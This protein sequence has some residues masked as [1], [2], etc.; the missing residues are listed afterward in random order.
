MFWNSAILDQLTNSISCICNIFVFTLKKIMLNKHYNIDQNLCCNYIG[1]SNASL[2]DGKMYK[3]DLQWNQLWHDSYNMQL[4]LSGVLF[5]G[6]YCSELCTYTE[7]IY[8]C[9]QCTAMI[10]VICLNQNQHL[11]EK[12][13]QKQNRDK[14]VGSCSFLF[15]RVTAAI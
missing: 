11:T 15:K 3:L 1:E 9:F 10:T 2:K 8:S 13:G 7:W 14:C 5:S 4:L 6:S 12:N